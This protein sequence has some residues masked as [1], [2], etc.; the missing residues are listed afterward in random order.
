MILLKKNKY[1]LCENALESVQINHFFAM[2]VIRNHVNGQVFVNHAN[3]PKVFYVKHP[4]G[5]SLLFGKTDDENFNNWLKKYISGEKTNHEYLQASP[6]SWDEI[7]QVWFSNIWSETENKQKIWLQTRAN[8][9]F[10]PNEFHKYFPETGNREIVKIDKEIF[11]SFEGSVV[12]NVFG[13]M[14]KIF[15]K[16]A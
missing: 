9:E 10:L 5:M 13:I 11:E 12:P 6:D 16:R 1:F 14:L 2:S 8:F 7:F 15:C 3:N 4:Y